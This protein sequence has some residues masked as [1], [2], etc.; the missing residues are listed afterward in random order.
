MAAVGN[1]R[2]NRQQLA[3]FLPSAEAIKAFEQLFANSYDTVPTSLESVEASAQA[4]QLQ[5]AEALG[6]LADIANV[7]S[8]ALYGAYQEATQQ[9]IYLPIA[10]QQKA[11]EIYIPPIALDKNSIGL[12]NVDNTSDA[13]KPVSTAQ[14]TALNSKADA[15]QSSWVAVTFSNSWVNFGGAYNNCE[16]FKDTLGTVHLRGLIKSGTMQ[17]AAFTL[18]A[19]FRPSANLFVPAISNNTIGSVI[20]GSDGTVKPWDGSN[21]WFSMDNIRFRV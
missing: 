15:A 5:A 19:G 7:L 13:N 8:L 20:I 12:G 6:Q 9:E 2:L 21:L 11:E 17:Q 18:P 14:Q 3:Q 1:L 16:Y 10:D 4:A